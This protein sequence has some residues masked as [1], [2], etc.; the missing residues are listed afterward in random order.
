MILPLDTGVLWT[1]ML[2]W[3]VV[4]PT[5]GANTLMVLHVAMTRT[6]L[7]VTAAIAGNMLGILVLAGGALLGWA[8]MLEA[9]PAMRLVVQIL[10]AAYLVYFGFRLIQRSRRSNVIPLEHPVQG[11]A[12]AAKP[13]DLR[14]TLALGF[15]TALS[16]A[17]AIAFIT[18]I[19]AVTGI[20]QG[21]VATGLASVAIMVA[22]N[23]TYLGILGWLFQRD[24]VRRGYARFRRPVEGTVGVLFAV[25]GGRLLYRE[26]M[27]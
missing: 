1:F 10:G 25:L 12:L 15:L 22:C 23:A 7:H 16:N 9:F 3:L 13:G 4:V 5:P 14:R 20:L 8:A 24:A 11:P 27:R 18:G 26:M 17:Q 6:P 19:Y 2:L 21:N